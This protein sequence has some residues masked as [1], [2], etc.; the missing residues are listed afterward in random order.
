MD[1]RAQAVIRITKQELT[2]RVTVIRGM[3]AEFSHSLPMELLLVI[4][5]NTSKCLTGLEKK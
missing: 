3:D 1:G 2:E 4:G 5:P